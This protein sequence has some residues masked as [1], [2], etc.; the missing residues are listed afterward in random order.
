MSIADKLTQIANGQQ[1][2]YD[3]GFA[4]GQKQG[5]GSYDRFW[6]AYQQNGTRTSYSIYEG[7]FAGPYWTDETFKPKYDM[8]VTNA[9][10][11]FRACRITDLREETVGVS[12]DFSGCKSFNYAFAYS[13]GSLKYLP[14]IDI[15]LATELPNTFDGFGGED[16]SLIVSETT[17]FTAT[18]FSGVK[19]LKHL[20][21]TGKI[22][23]SLT[24]SSARNLSRASFEGLIGALSPNVTG[25]TLTLSEEAMADAFGDINSQEWKDLVAT[26]PSGW[27]VTLI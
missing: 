8:R 17:K 13:S 14:T 1:K 6:D 27:T 21:I 11:M 19:N 10:M 23:V 25:Q 22:G 20:T 5:D 3:K 26:K 2:V 4:E 12:M 15:S 16:L 7:G 24:L 18:T 9:Q